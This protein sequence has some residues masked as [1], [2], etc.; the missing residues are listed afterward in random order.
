MLYGDGSAP[1]LGYSSV[2]SSTDRPMFSDPQL[3]RGWYDLLTVHGRS[4][5]P[6]NANQVNNERINLNTAP[7]AV[8]M[9]LG[10]EEADVDRLIAQR[11]QNGDLTT[12]PRTWARQ[13]ISGAAYNAIQNRIV[14]R[15]LRY[16]ADILAVSGNGRAFKRVR[17]IMDTQNLTTSPTTGVQ[18]PSIVYR[19]DITERGWPIDPSILAAMRAG[20]LS[21][22]GAGRV[23]WV[24]GST[25]GA[26]R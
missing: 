2:F 25:G 26:N 15:S 9:C 19:R 10:L 13:A 16:S 20:E 14:G 6:A 5:N 11:S 18:Y 12:D 1:P 3:A 7:R 24:T 23:G 4:R 17:I 8:L 21:L 22:S